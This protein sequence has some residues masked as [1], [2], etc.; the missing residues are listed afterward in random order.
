MANYEEFEKIAWEDDI[1]VSLAKSLVSK[2]IALAHPNRF[3]D[4]TLVGSAYMRDYGKSNF[5]AALHNKTAKEIE[6]LF[7]ESDYDFALQ[8]D[9]FVLESLLKT[10]PNLKLK[11]VPEED[12]YGKESL[13]KD[14]YT[15]SIQDLMVADQK[16]L[17]SVVAELAK[18]TTGKNL[19][20]QLENKAFLNQ[21]VQ[22]LFVKDLKAIEM[23]W[24]KIPKDFFANYLWKRSPT[25]IGKHALKGVFGVFEKLAS[26]GNHKKAP[27]YSLKELNVAPA[28]EFQGPMQAFAVGGWAEAQDVVAQ[29][30]P[31]PVAAEF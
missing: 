20:R 4:H 2:V 7:L 14:V 19:L 27:K 9:T 21:E 5:Y 28:G 6:A 12:E 11:E 29:A 15:T 31:Q 26:E 13:L 30:A 1:R 18:Y 23:L 17:P 25:F 8:V 3:V 16:I 10:V 22:F 24:R